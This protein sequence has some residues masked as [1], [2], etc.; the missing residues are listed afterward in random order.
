MARESPQAVD[1]LT[2]FCNKSF[3][4][5]KGSL[6]TVAVGNP[7]TL[8]VGPS[9]APKEKKREKRDIATTTRSLSK[10]SRRLPHRSPNR[11]ESPSQARAPTPKTTVVDHPMALFGGDSK[12]SKVFV[13]SCHRMTRTS[14][15]RCLRMNCS[16]PRSSYNVEGCVS[17]VSC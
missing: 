4:R 6:E 1:I 13:S 8:G 12:F 9:T 17:S 15:P 5:A 7:S 2:A 3:G 10:T 14:L 16:Q 11:L